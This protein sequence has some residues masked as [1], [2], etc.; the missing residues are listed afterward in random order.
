MALILL[1]SVFKPLHK[2]SFEDIIGENMELVKRK[3]NATFK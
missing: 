3:I 2:K 1:E